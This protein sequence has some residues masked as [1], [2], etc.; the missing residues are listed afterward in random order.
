MKKHWVHDYETLRDCFVAVFEEYKT[1]ERRI[2]VIC[3]FRNDLPRLLKFLQQNVDNKEW[4]I[5]FNGLKF[6]AQITEFIIRFHKTLL[7]LTGDR[8]A[9]RIYEKAQDCIARSNMNEWQEYGEQNMAIKQIDIFSLNHWDSPAKSAS[10]K[11]VQ[12]TTDW[13]N[14]QDMPIDHTASITTEDE[15]RTVVRYCINDVSATKYIAME[16]CK[17]LIELRGTLTQKF[18]VR[19][20]SASEPKISKELFLLFLSTKL[21]IPKKRLRKMRTK[22]KFIHVQNILLPYLQF[23]TP[24]FQKMHQSFK[25]L[26]INAHKTKDA[27]EYILD[28]RGVKTKLALGG[29]HGAKKGVFKSGNGMI[30]MSSDVVSYYPNLAIRN[31]WAPAHLP[32]KEFCEQYE[33]FFDERRKIPKKDPMNYIYKIVLNATFGLSID[34]HSLLY[35]PQFG[36]QITINGQLTLM[37]LY[38]MLT[39]SVPG[40]VPLM[41]NTDGLEMMIPE[42]FKDKYLEVCKEWEKIT[43]LELE[44]DQYDKLI[45]PDVNNYVGVFKMKEVTRQEFDDAVEENPHNIYK[46]EDGKYFMSKTKTKGRFDFVDLALHKNKSYLAIRKALFYYF[47]H[48]THP[49]DYLK[50]NQNIFDYCAGKRATGQ[51]RFIE[52][53]MKN[54]ELH[55]IPIQKTLRFYCSKTGSKIIKFNSGDARRLHIEKA[56]QQTVFNTYEDKPWADYNVDLTFYIRKIN[57]EIEKLIPKAT[58]DQISLSF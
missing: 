33:W 43:Q 19:L 29:I 14:I 52:T 30:I 3:R 17:K 6:D 15:L 57:K 9:H 41:Q 50:T 27:F 5:S 56:G 21:D 26:I 38:E 51:W 32:Q 34:T 39:E 10:L 53:Y 47:V 13:H 55:E 23:K 35:D 25:N 22:R 37:L 12:F 40:C 28:Y 16:K 54:G 18:G 46:V 58:T 48:G 42:Q 20:Y 24:A 49:A 11:W 7:K 31:K 45:I 44:H 4:H 36:M 8:V 2:F 1:E